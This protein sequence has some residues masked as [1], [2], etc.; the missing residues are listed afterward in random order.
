M[1]AGNSAKTIEFLRIGN[2][3][4]V[5]KNVNRVVPIYVL[6][7]LLEAD[8]E[9]TKSLQAIKHLVFDA[10]KALA[11]GL[12][13]RVDVGEQ[14][15]ADL[16][17][18]T[19]G[20]L[21]PERRVFRDKKG[22]GAG[23]HGSLFPLVGGL[24]SPSASDDG[25]GRRVRALMEGHNTDWQE[26]LCNLLVPQ[27]S[28]DPATSFA[29]SLLGGT[30]GK[31][32]K[33]EFKR[34]RKRLGGLDGACAELIDNLIF[35]TG[36]ARRV[37]IIRRIAS[38]AYLVSILRMV[39]GPLADSGGDLPLVLVYCGL[40]PGGASEPLVRAASKSFSNWV[41]ESWNACAR[42]MFDSLSNAPTLPGAKRHEKV[43]QQVHH[44][45]AGRLEGRQKELEGVIEALGPLFEKAN[46]S[47]AWCKEAMESDVS[48]F[49]KPELARRVRSLG[50]NIGFAGPDRGLKPRLTL[51]TPLLGVLVRGIVGDGTM[52]LGE[53]V[54][55][56]AQRFGLVLG[57]GNSDDIADKMGS[58][59]SEGFDIY[60]L[61]VLN[62]ELLRTRLLRA[63]LARSYSDSHTEVFCNV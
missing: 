53:F 13:P 26:R 46:L 54:S 7:N 38:G 63:G 47:L 39:V 48:G 25:L 29:F 5:G 49:A 62:Q 58:L 17:D 40:P 43:R 55:V 3:W 11:D 35:S 14:D 1:A 37:P 57:L 6:H 60:E 4:L 52:E 31:I 30:A 23:K 27:V 34:P 22:G 56:V 50:A 44:A 24:V 42:C 36:D 2:P 15:Y 10:G 16:Q 8:F 32:S 19:F 59:G 12:S 33:K 41:G 18:T 9:R 61:L 28:H 21:A 51:D 45:L 20:L